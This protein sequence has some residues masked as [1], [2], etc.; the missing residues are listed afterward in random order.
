MSGGHIWWVEFNFTRGGVRCD[1]QREQT[2]WGGRRPLQHDPPVGEF[3]PLDLCSSLVS[4][5]ISLLHVCP[6]FL[7]PKFGP[8][9]SLSSPPPPLNLQLNIRGLSLGKKDPASVDLPPRLSTCSVL[10]VA[11]VNSRK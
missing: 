4:S 11:D 10:W 7:T 8:H 1:V 9:R 3:T 5:Q 2:Y 6:T